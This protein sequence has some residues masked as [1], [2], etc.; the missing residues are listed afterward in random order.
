MKNQTLI[1]ILWFISINISFSQIIHNDSLDVFIDQLME[2][3]ELP[4]LS[5][6]IVHKGY[7]IYSKGF[8]TREFGKNSPVDNHTLFGIGS[9]S[10]SFVATTMGILV[11]EGKLNWDD[12]VVDYLPYFELYDPY[13]TENFTIRDLLTHRSGLNN[14]SGGTLLIS[15]DFSRQEIIKGLKHLKPISG[16]RDAPAYQNVMWIVAS[17]I[18][19]IVSGVAWEEFLQKRVFD[20]LEMNN[21][22][23]KVAD[24]EASANLAKPHI[25]NDNFQRVQIEQE[26]ADNSMPAGFIFSSANE[27]ASYM[28]L[29]LN[30]GVI[31]Q[32]TIISIKTLEEIFKPQ[33]HYQ[34]L[35]EPFQN[36]FTSYGFGW[37]L[38]PKNGHKIIE[39]SG[40]IDGA[41]ANLMMVEDLDFGVIVLS[42]ASE[43]APFVLTHKV[44]YDFLNNEDY[45]SKDFILGLRNRRI[46]QKQQAKKDFEK[47]RIKD[48]K[49]SLYLKSYAGN[50]HDKM[51]GD[52]FINAEGEDSLEISF[53]QS[54]LFKGKLKHWH[55]DT[56][57]IDWN[58][59]RVPDGFLTFNFNAKHEIL[60]FRIDQE[61]LLD[62]DF[63]EL[64]IK[65]KKN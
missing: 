40:G 25:L 47:S 50:Y 36:E 4:G 22:T 23:A 31:G 18:V 2:E 30:K 6:S 59:I 3:F 13:V 11:D 8:G 57:L 64:E 54:H 9:I 14:V 39:H 45:N 10:K 65:K 35:P 62:V 26:K 33:N 42:N 5:I 43:L 17:E 41:T 55:Y 52:I 51:Y 12:R 29:L 44:L 61:N 19:K 7:T 49:P 24:R 27:M 28:K 60:G 46:E 38:T 34:A 16:F 15:T 37:W 56:F 63:G 21:T 1:I 53:P 32:D 58:D 48:T 20:K